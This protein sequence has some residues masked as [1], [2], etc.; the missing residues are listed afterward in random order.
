[1]PFV[2]HVID[3]QQGGCGKVELGEFRVFGELSMGMQEAQV[4]CI[5]LDLDR[6]ERQ[7]RS[8][9]ECLQVQLQAL[10]QRLTTPLN[11]YQRD[12][13]RRQAGHGLAGHRTQHAVQI[14][15]VIQAD[16]R[17][18]GAIHGVSPLLDI[19]G[20]EPTRAP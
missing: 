20:R 12:F 7:G 2:E 5:T 3:H 13:R 10:R 8:T 11:A 14:V 18:S 1:M 9:G 6:V 16:P 4:V 19:T 17:W 15:F